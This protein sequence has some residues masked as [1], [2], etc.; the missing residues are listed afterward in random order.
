MICAPGQTRESI[1]QM[2]ASLE[3]YSK[4]PLALTISQAAQQQKVSL[5]PVSEIGEKPGEGLK[6]TIDGRQVLITGRKKF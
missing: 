5:A 6:G 3:Q 4:H 2:A 1:L